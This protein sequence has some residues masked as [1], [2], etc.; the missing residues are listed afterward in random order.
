MMN[1]TIYAGNNVHHILF[2]AVPVK[3]LPYILHFPLNPTLASRTSSS[4]SDLSL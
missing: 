1:K 2:T 3:C 4:V